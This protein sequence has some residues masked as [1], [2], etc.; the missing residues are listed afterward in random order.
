[1]SLLISNTLPNKLITV[2]IRVHTHKKSIV[3]APYV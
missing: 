1:M 3:A 2:K